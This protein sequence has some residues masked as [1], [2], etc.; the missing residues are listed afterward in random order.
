MKT[1]LA[2]VLALVSLGVLGLAAPDDNSGQVLEA[3]NASSYRIYLEQ[4]EDLDP[5]LGNITIYLNNSSDLKVGEWVYFDIREGIGEGF[6]AD[7]YRQIGQ[8]PARI[9]QQVGAA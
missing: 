8:A 1:L 6:R 4:S 5:G 3:L 7:A 9:G 2:L